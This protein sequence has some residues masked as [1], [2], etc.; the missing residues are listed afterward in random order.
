[1]FYTGSAG[2]FLVCDISATMPIALRKGLSIDRF[3][4]DENSPDLRT[5]RFEWEA[6]SAKQTA[7][8]VERALRCH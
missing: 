5:S 1:M 6:L 4:I 2:K 7:S 8:S 3:Q